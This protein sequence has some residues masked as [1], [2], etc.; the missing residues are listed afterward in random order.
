MRCQPPPFSR[1]TSTLRP[2]TERSAAGR[3]GL[4]DRLP[5]VDQDAAGRKV[6]TSNEVHQAQVLGLGIVDEM[7][8]SIDQLA[9]IVRRDRGCHANGNSAG[10]VGEEV[11]KQARKHLG[12]LFLAVV[13]EPKIDGA[14]VE[15]CHELHRDGRE[16]GLGVAISSG[17][18]A[19]DIAEI[20]LPVDQRVAKSEI[21]GEA[22]H[23]IID[24][25]VAVRVVL[26]DDVAHDACGFLVSAGRIEAKQPHRPQQPSMDGLQPV[27]DIGKRSSG[28]RR[29]RVDE[30]AFGKR[31][32]EGRFD[33]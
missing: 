11:G 33:D 19:V 15:T 32:I 31:G 24:G 30:I 8:G 23:G 25:L 7:N 5:A 1:S 16:P 20:A 27:A 29:K 13:G 18:I 22:D 26:A 4:G 21:L 28:D 17:I 2:K 10:A 14:L 12:L 3:I 9:D 6:R